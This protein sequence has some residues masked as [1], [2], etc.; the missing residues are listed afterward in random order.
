[1]KHTARLEHSAHLK[2]HPSL[3]KAVTVLALALSAT[4][5]VGCKSTADTASRSKGVR[6]LDPL[7]TAYA[8]SYNRR[9][10]AVDEEPAATR[11]R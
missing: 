3:A 11:T 2:K 9:S 10:Y 8:Q 6:L 1:M 4:L 5:I 7:A